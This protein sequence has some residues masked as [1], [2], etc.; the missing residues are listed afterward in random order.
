MESKLFV[1]HREEFIKNMKDGSFAV[2]YSGD[3]PHKTNDQTYV[4]EPNRNYYYL[5]GCERGNFIL[6]LVKGSSFAQAFL[7]IEEPS[8]YATKWLGRRLTKEEAS[9]LS[10]IDLK[11]VKYVE[12]F[13]SFIHTAVLANSRGALLKKPERL[14]LDLYKY[15]PFVTP[16]SLTQLQFLTDVYPEIKV[17]SANDILD[18]MRRIKSSEEVAEIEKAIAYGK[19]G[20]EAVLKFAKPG[21][22]ERELEAYYEYQIKMSGSK[23]ISFDSIVASGKNATILHYIDNFSTIQDGSL[24]LLDLGAKNGVYSS[25]ISRTFPINGKFSDRQKQ[26]YEIVLRTN[27]NIIEMIQ[28]GVMVNDLNM[29][30]KKMLTEET[31]KIGLIKEDYEIDKYYYHGVS[32]YLGLDT[33]DVGTYQEPLQPGVV[34]TVEPGLY[35]EEEGIGIRIEDNILV[36]ENGRRNLSESIKKEWKDIESL[37]K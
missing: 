33:H 31:K 30:A 8:D 11:H 2:F 23:G 7:F 34:L 9:N 18:S 28:P 22:N 19:A 36:T 26:I 20:I 35:I 29:A 32:H 12:E 16:F 1:R 5:T 37:M 14:Y 27:K 21:V 6:L 17:K 13:K 25:D 10:G 3:A 15:K 4:Y 24:V